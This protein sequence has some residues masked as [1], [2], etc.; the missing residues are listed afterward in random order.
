[1]KYPVHN[2]PKRITEGIIMS[3]LL[4]TPILR[5]SGKFHVKKVTATI[6]ISR[7]E[8]QELSSIVTFDECIIKK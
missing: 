8:W 3:I 5:G 1:M 4:I 6:I 7:N 2:K